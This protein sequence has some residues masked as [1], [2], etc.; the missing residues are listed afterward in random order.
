MTLTSTSSSQNPLG[1]TSD[2]STQALVKPGDE[3][4]T[5]FGYEGP[6]DMPALNREVFKWIQS[7]DLSHAL[8]NVRR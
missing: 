5:L 4:D 3:K 8:K 6:P 1:R 2:R 7:L